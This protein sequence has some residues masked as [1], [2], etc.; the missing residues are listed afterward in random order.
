MTILL[1]ASIAFLSYEISKKIIDKKL[2]SKL[3]NYINIKND[4]YYD[5]LLKHYEKNKKIK[6]N[7]KLNVFHKINIMIDRAALN[8]SIIINPIT[9]LLYSV[10]CLFGAYTIVKEIFEIPLLS[11]IVSFPAISIPFLIL[12]ILA[13]YKEQKVE[14]VIL[15]FLLQLKNYTK[16]NNDIVYAFQEVKTIEPLQSYIDKFVF[17]INRGVKFETAMEHLKEKIHIKSFIEL[18]NHIQ[19]CYLY[20]GNFSELIKKSYEIIDEMQREKEKR[21]QETRGARLVLFIL[22]FLDLIVYFT[23][24]K[25]NNENFR[26]MRNTIIGNAIL[27]WNFISMWL[28]VFLSNSVKK[29]DY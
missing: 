20:G 13:N 16:I 24:I 1:F 18:L 22:V 11:A 26:I 27:Y 7:T 2:L 23:F 8:R 14:R 29:L 6:L 12:H 4:S 28:L 19:Y 9:I 17:E 25:N 10:I 15:N 5:K 21:M 3:N